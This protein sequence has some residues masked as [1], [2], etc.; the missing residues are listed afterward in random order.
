MPTRTNATGLRIGDDAV[1]ASTGKSWKEWYAALDEAGAA[2]LNHREIVAWLAENHGVGGWW[3]QM[4]AVSYEQARGLRAPHEKP[5]GFEISVSR[6]A[7]GTVEHLF[8][9]WS[10][11]RKRKRWLPD[12][13]FTIRRS[14]AGKS[15]RFTWVD[16]KSDVNVA[17]SAKGTGKCMVVVQ[18]AKLPSAAAAKKMKAY[19]ASALDS[20][21]EQ[22]EG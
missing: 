21:K 19:W 12:T 9:A 4:V 2:K 16:G 13:A 5:G 17:F 3:R 18:H 11:A 6:T 20:L 22:T 15:L 8:A 7:A 1:R 10:D 14:T